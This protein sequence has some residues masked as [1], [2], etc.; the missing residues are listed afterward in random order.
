[1]SV[2]GTSGPSGLC[3]HLS[4]AELC[5]GTGLSLWPVF[6]SLCGCHSFSKHIG[7]RSN[8]KEEGSQ[9]EKG[10]GTS[11]ELALTSP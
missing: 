4:P 1:M 9:E 5:V 6:I 8:H 7:A 2:L 11:P 10:K 3:P